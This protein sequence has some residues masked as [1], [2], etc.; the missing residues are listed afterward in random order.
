MMISNT[1]TLTNYTFTYFIACIFMLIFMFILWIIYVIFYEK[2][3]KEHWNH[4][5]HI[6]KDSFF[7]QR[8]I[9][10]NNSINFEMLVKI[11]EQSQKLLPHKHVI[12]I[13]KASVPSE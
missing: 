8:S 4:F 9:N 3:F 2:I 6:K 12:S 13:K 5:L 1:A 11:R 10:R 7:I